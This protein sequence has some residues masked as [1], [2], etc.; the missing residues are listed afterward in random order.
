MPQCLFCGKTVAVG[1]EICPRCGVHRDAG[2]NVEDLESQIRS[3]LAQ[4]K[5][6]DAV[7]LYRQR[8]DVSLM[9]AKTAVEALGQ[10]RGLQSSAGKSGD[11]KAEILSLLG[12]GQKLK[13]VKLQK[14]QTGSSL[15]EAKA[16]VEA[17]AAQ[18]GLPVSQGV[19]C[20]GVGGVFL[21]S[22]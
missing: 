21:V 20:A 1:A 4:G 6:L 10:G 9:E 14:Q 15:M 17:L 22:S 7:K 3:L 13:A 16:A 18:H 12:R 2:E 19:G 8:V 5:K 11:V